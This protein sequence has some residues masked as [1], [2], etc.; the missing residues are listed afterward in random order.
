MSAATG[1]GGAVLVTG[2]R[3][4]IGS[5]VAARLVAAGA[6]VRG[7]DAAAPATGGAATSPPVRPSVDVHRGSTTD[8][9]SWAHLLAGVDTVV[10]TAAVVSNVA[11]RHRMHEVNV[12]GTGRV[13]AAAARAGV[14]RFVHLSSVVVHGFD[15]PAWVDE[16]H[17]VQ[18]NGDAYVD[19]KVAGEHLVLA[20]HAAGDIEVVVL[21]PGDVY[22]PGS[23]PWV[24]LPL[25]YLAAGQAV[26]PARGRGVFSPT[27][28][29]NLVDGVLAAVVT[30]A[31]AGRVLHLTDGV[32]TSCAAYFGRLGALVGARPRC[33]PTPLA[34]ALATTTGAGLRALGRPSELC[35]ASMR[36][37]ARTG[38]YRIDRARTVLG[39]APAVDLDT[40][41]ER[42]AVWARQAGLVPRVAP[43]PGAGR[44][45]RRAAPP[46]RRS[47]DDD[48]ARAAAQA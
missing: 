5:A 28:L 18:A 10:H 43:P 25:T 40:G 48:A 7:V 8:P 21:R 19:T 14:R 44:A 20:A 45:D 11:P 26:L 1:A 31:A 6:E 33:L 23:R 37:L 15:L 32:A 46:A 34:T 12:V 35:P 13:L 22:G 4:F 16:D 2:A 36:L 41:L 27:Y 9:G 17:P 30:P 42:V 47:P 3:G 39:Y 24:V 29:D 38:S